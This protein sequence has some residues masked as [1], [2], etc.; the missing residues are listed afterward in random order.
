MAT[1]YDLFK[2]DLKAFPDVN[3]YGIHSEVDSVGD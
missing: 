2:I 3:C 1:V